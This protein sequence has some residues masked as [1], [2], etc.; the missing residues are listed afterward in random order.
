MRDALRDSRVLTAILMPLALGLLYSFMFSD[1]NVRTQKAKV[2]IV[3]GG[4][5]QLTTVPS[6]SRPV[7]PCA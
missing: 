7:A 1:E 2:G 5:T 3:S 6:R 4:P